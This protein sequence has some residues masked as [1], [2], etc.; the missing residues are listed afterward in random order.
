MI[1]NWPGSRKSRCT[2]N[3]HVLSVG[4]LTYKVGGIM[5][6]IERERAKVCITRA[7]VNENGCCSLIL[8]KSHIA[9]SINIGMLENR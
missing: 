2:C 1:I 8:T 3:L 4:V 6:N 5:Q 9:L 7:A